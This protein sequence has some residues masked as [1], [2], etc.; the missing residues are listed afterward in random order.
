MV[1]F[2]SPLFMKGDWNEGGFFGVYGGVVRIV[3][4]LTLR[5]AFLFVKKC[6]LR[7]KH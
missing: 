2:F 5:T 3:H 1:L 6:F 7:Y 4:S